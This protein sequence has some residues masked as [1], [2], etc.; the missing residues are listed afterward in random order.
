[1]LWKI[2]VEQNQFGKQGV[3]KNQLTKTPLEFR[4]VLSLA[5]TEM[6]DI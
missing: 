3:E 1:M 2:C 6:H 5:S 4:V